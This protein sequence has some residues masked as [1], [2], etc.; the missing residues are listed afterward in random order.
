MKK[1][2]NYFCFHVVPEVIV[3]PSGMQPAQAGLDRHIFSG[4][5]FRSSET[6]VIGELEASLASRKKSKGRSKIDA[7][8]DKM[9]RAT[10]ARLNQYHVGSFELPIGDLSL[11]EPGL[12]TRDVELDHVFF[13]A[14]Q[15]E[16]QGASYPGKA[17]VACAFEVLFSCVV[18]TFGL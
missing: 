8:Y 17:A 4:K 12:A 7:E 10:L 2:H 16:I 6:G 9:R 14:D 13:L 3:L 5:G 18:H 15:M 11:P 1:V